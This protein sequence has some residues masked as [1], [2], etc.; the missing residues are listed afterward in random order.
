MAKQLNVNLAFTADTGK[1]KQQLQEL[2]QTLKNLSNNTAQN[3]PLGITKE[4]NQAIGDV[5]KLR[6]ALNNAIS[7]STGKLDLGQFRQEL[8]KAGLSAQTIAQQLSMLGPEGKQAF[9]Q[10]SQ[11]VTTAEIPLKRTSALLDNFATTLKNTARW[12]ISSSILH[13]FMG[14]LQGAYGYAQDLNKSLN[15]I[16]VVTGQSVDEMSQFAE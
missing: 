3:S 13:G 5:A 8:N 15:N 4:I 6:V 9:A 7:S 14:A 16:R 10:L 12:Q 1:A 11:A 2:Q